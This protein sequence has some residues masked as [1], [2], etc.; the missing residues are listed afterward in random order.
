MYVERTFFKISGIIGTSKDPLHPHWIDIESYKVDANAV[1]TDGSGS[2]GRSGNGSK[3]HGESAFIKRVDATSASFMEAMT[4]GTHFDE[5]IL[6]TVVMD[7]K[8]R[9]NY[10]RVRFK[11]VT[12]TSY[13]AGVSRSSNSPLEDFTISYVERET[14]R[15]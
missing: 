10:L 4:K 8:V 11:G 9:R 12:V 15:F 2:S 3:K 13:A 7:G 5:A 1:F 6:E 14:G